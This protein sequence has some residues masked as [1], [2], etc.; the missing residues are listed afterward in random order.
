VQ[1]CHTKGTRL[2]NLGKPLG[3]KLEYKVALHTQYTTQL[4][5]RDK[6]PHSMASEL[7]MRKQS[8]PAWLQG[9][10]A[11][12]APDRQWLDPWWYP[13]DCHQLEDTSSN[14]RK[15]SPLRWRRPVANIQHVRSGKRLFWRE[16]HLRHIKR[17]LPVF[18]HNPSRKK[19][20]HVLG[21]L[22]GLDHPGIAH[23]YCRSACFSRV[24]KIATYI[25]LGARS[26]GS[27]SPRHGQF[28]LPECGWQD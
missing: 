3:S 13:P 16:S 8:R 10:H 24:Q 17:R 14:G 12:L 23:N 5:F 28:W 18:A 22:P 20:G 11:T 2:G 1:C 4:G 6:R 9:P 26:R 27:V 25:S 19:L 21:E 15:A 7:P